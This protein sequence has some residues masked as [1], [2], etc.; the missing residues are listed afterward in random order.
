MALFPD[1]F[2]SSEERREAN[3]ISILIG[4]IGTVSGA[5]VPP[6]LITFGVLESYIIQGGI[7]FLIVIIVLVLAIPGCRDDQVA[8]DRYLA[9][10]TNR[11]KRTPFL[12]IFKTSMKQKNF[13]AYVLI[14]FLYQVS[15]KSM[16]ASI[17]YIVRFILKMEASIITLIMAFFLISVLISTPFWV[18]L[19]HK[20]NDN[21]KVFLIAGILLLIFTIPLIFVNTVIG[22]IIGL[23]IWGTAIGGFWLMQMPIFGDVMDEA[24]VQTGKHEE[25]T[26]SGVHIFFNRLSVAVQAISFAMVH[27]FTGFVEGAETQSTQA[28]VGIQIHFAV[29]PAIALLLGV[30]IF[31]RL[32]DLTPERIQEN[33][34][35]LKEMEA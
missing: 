27:T 18:K 32:Y 6:L 9:T 19:A 33:Q 10:Y 34:L 14:V 28:I 23:I 5:L 31:W 12:K 4:I 26:Y 11:T 29:I 35:K 16:I 20:K 8:V 21:R 3:G 7:I 17:P 25:G 13:V 15:N 22:F 1:K 24:A 30:L 2:R